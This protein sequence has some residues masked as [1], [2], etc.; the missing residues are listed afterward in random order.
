MKRLKLLPT[1]LVLFFLPAIIYTQTSDFVKFETNKTLCIF[2][3]LETAVGAHSVS[4]T[5]RDYIKTK[6]GDDEKF[7]KLLERYK[8]IY[9]DDRLEREDYPFS[10]HSSRTA[11]DFI[12]IATSN[13]LD[14]NDLS[15]RIIGYLPNSAHA[16]F[17]SIMMEIEPY[18]DNLVWNNVQE[19]IQRIENQLAPY[20]KKI[21]EL[22]LQIS[23]FYGSNWDKSIPFKVMLYPIPARGG[24]TTAIPKGNTLI[25]SFLTEYENDYMGRLGVIIHEMCHILYDEQPLDLQKQIDEWFV[26]ADSDY[27]TLAYSFIDEGMATAIGNGWAYLQIHGEMDTIEWY[28]DAYIDG[29]AHSIFDLV[30]SYLDSNKSMDKDFVDNA[31]TLFGKTFPK[32]N[33]NLN[34]LFNEVRIYANTEEKSEIDQIFGAVQQ[35]FRLRSAWFS[36]PINDTKSKETFHEKQKTKLFIIDNNN[37]STIDVLKNEFEELSKPLPLNKTFIYSFK[38]KDTKSNVIIV[39]LKSLND[40]MPAFEK[41][42]EMEFIDHGKIVSL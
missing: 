26:N 37:T 34:T 22:F 15:N 40:A 4:S 7:Q 42:K 8:A 28:N 30:S 29:Y 3:F 13:A 2:S 5:Y 11:K 36:T 35:N 19:Q 12:W 9:M 14:I 21:E 27:N 31:I 24:A 38:E 1:L 32:S 10:R 39:N 25:C 23:Q 6:L 33:L 20:G 41:L 16:E 18:Y 17:I